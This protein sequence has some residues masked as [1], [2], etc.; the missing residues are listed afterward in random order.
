MLKR[1]EKNNSKLLTDI[2]WACDFFGLNGDIEK[3]LDLLGC[4]Q[5]VLKSCINCDYTL[6]LFSCL[7]AAIFDLDFR[8]NSSV[9]C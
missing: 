3:L 1:N 4:L 9:F 2:I 7:S 5:G 8:R 6:I